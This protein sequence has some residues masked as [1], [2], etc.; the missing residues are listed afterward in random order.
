M[1]ADPCALAR[2][3]PTSRGWP[4]LRRPR[5]RGPDSIIDLEVSLLC[6]Q[7][8]PSNSD[9]LLRCT[10]S[11]DG[12]RA[13]LALSR[14]RGSG[15]NW[16]LLKF[17]GLHR[18]LRR[19]QHLRRCNRQI[20][21]GRGPCGRLLMARP[22]V[23]GCIWACGVKRRAR[24]HAIMARVSRSEAASSLSRGTR[25]PSVRVH[26]SSNCAIWISS[27]RD[28]QVCLQYAIRIGCA[29]RVSQFPGNDATTSRQTWACAS[30]N[31]DGGAG[32][33][34][35]DVSTMSVDISAEDFR[36]RCLIPHY[37][38]ILDV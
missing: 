6:G 20:S 36:P 27:K 4:T 22:A 18:M 7:I 23:L 10:S 9:L 37:I 5:Q 11:L 13:I 14:S 30:V 29:A 17:D 15:S 21:Q 31:S 24:A 12:L 34:C 8:K 32:G 25:P 26:S 2:N 16:L 35:R 3:D 1:S 33:V 28:R 19:R 38:K